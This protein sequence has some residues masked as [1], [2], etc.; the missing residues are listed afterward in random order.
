MNYPSFFIKL[1]LFMIKKLNEFFLTILLLS[2]VY[3]IF[4]IICHF[5]KYNSSSSNN[6]S[7]VIILIIFLWYYFLLDGGQNPPQNILK[8]KR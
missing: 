5:N 8:K 3:K 6:Y 1:I 4:K 2:L 7:I